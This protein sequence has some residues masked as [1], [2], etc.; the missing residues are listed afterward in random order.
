L[1]ADPE[2]VVEVATSRF[3]TNRLFRDAGSMATASVATAALGFVFW[4]VAARLFPPEELGVMTAVL[5]VITAVSLVVA[6]SAGDPYISL[7]P[8][9]GPARERVYR[10]GQRVWFAMALVC[11]VAGAL[12][13]IFALPQ[14]HK[15]VWVGVVVAVGVVLWSGFI[16]QN[17]TMTSIGR[18]NWM[19][20]T[21]VAASLGKIL[22]LPLLTLAS[23]SN[24]VELAFIIPAGLAVVVVRPFIIRRIRTGRDLPMTATVPED[25][26][27]GEFNRLSVQMVILVVFWMGASTL[28]PFLVTKFAGPA[29]GA[30]FAL[31]LTIVQTLDYIAAAMG[32]S[33]SV[34]AS[35]APEHGGSMAR[36]ILIRSTAVVAVVAVLMVAV[37]PIG[38]RLL[39]EQYGQM[40]SLAVIA[41]LCVGSLFQVFY[42]VWAGLQRA[43]RKMRAPLVF[44]VL[45]AI[46]L[47]SLIPTLSGEYGAVGGAIAMFASQFFLA[48]AGT[49]FYV[50]SRIRAR[51][52]DT[53][54]AT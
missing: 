34:H 37:V 16:L 13:T 12:V 35:S 33:L 30:L 39:Q 2:S 54:G 10:R 51:T 36:A 32:V 47:Y 5:S 42:I 26:I 6:A 4:A 49:T 50:V 52:R 21:N 46:L 14:V 3:G 23:V 28:T 22:L 11:G 45:A 15:S 17:S 24:S 48:C 1:T 40:G 53:A 41:T 43:R 25:R 29:E 9:A 8:A 44:N 27:M 18:A 31:C 38:L 20:A 19:P 7:L